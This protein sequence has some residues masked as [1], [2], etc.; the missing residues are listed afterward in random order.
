MRSCKEVADRSAESNTSA[1]PVIVMPKRDFKILNL[2][3]HDSLAIGGL[4]SK[5]KLSNNL[6]EDG[7]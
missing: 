2:E 4:K 1:S 3:E 5:K 6:Q 7:T